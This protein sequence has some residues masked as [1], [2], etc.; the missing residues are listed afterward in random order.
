MKALVLIDIQQ[1]FDDPKWGARNNP[2]AEAVASKVLDYWRRQKWPVFHVR[3]DSSGVESP[4]HPDKVGNQFKEVVRPIAGEPVIR[5][6]VNSA[7]IGT[8]LHVDL[9][10]ATADEVVFVGLTTPY[11]VSTS[12]RRA[13]N[14]GY[15]TYVISD[16][17]AAFEWRAH[18]GRLVSA[19]DM[20]FYA[21]AALHGEFATVLGSTD[22]LK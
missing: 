19:D 9:Q 13:G 1:G 12:A 4:L 6:R 11:C 16:A 14:L 7:F 18:D 22:L 15:R 20:H 10:Q 21:L 2:S 5:K 3:H 17:T 8:K